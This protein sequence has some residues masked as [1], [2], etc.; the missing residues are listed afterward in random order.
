MNGGQ[1]GSVVTPGD[2]E[3]S[4]LWTQIRSGAMPLVGELSDDDKALIYNWIAAGAARQGSDPVP[5]SSM[6]LRLED[7]EITWAS[8]N[9]AENG[10]TVPYISAQL[11][12]PASCAAA[13]D[14]EQLAA[15]LPVVPTPTAAP[16]PVS[17]PTPAQP[18]ENGSNDAAGNTGKTEE[19]RPSP[20][21]AQSIG[22]RAA[23]LNLAAP[24]ESDPWLVP[25]GGF[26]AE[27][28]LAPELQGHSI[29]ALT[30]A[31]DGRL[32]IALDIPATGDFDPNIQFDPYSAVR[33]IVIWHSVS[34][35][36]YYEILRDSSRITGM[37]WHEGALYLNRAGEVGRI[38][39]WRRL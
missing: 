30:F 28:F 3:A 6:W 34:K 35:D 5:A 26:C 11:A 38:P 27:Q 13:P 18:P 17:T 39:G 14:A 15:Y 10:G 31:P 37:A 32:F 2:P 4:L 9:C 21:A 36:S 23:P 29:T 24:S 22:I 12:L 1:S 33:S 20:A 16:A 8:H 7:G 19:V 25:L